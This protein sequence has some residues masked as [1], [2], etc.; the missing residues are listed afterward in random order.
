MIGENGN[1]HFQW[2]V[3]CFDC[4]CLSFMA[5]SSVTSSASRSQLNMFSLI[6]LGRRD[7]HWL[8]DFTVAAWAL[9]HSVKC[10]EIVSSCRRGRLSSTWK[11]FLYPSSVILWL[12]ERFKF[13]SF[14]KPPL[15][16]TLAIKAKYSWK[17]NDKDLDFNNSRLGYLNQLPLPPPPPPPPKV[18]NVQY[19][20]FWISS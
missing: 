7:T 8:R 18:A 6:R 13:S 5:V 17:R 19:S 15:F 2:K 9:I 14:W 20:I 4:G 10:L 11:K 12:I 1:I 16:A 3:K